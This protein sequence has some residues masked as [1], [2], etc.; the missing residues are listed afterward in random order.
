MKREAVAVL[1]LLLLLLPMF[2]GIRRVKD[3]SRR[4]RDTDKGE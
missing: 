4:R 1:L 2:A 3:I